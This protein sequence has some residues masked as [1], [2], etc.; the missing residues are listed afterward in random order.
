LDAL[1]RVAKAGLM[2]QATADALGAAYVFLRQVE[3]RIQYLDDQQTHVLPTRDDDLAWIAQTL[4][5][6]APANF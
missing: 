5:M 3:H 2:P 4:G 1:Q 6:P